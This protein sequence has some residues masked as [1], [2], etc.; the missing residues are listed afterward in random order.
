[1]EE[2]PSGKSQNHRK[3]TG[4]VEDTTGNRGNTLALPSST[5]PPGIFYQSFLLSESPWKLEANEPGN[6]YSQ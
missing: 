3:G 6:C 1:M 4:A 5:P 2:G